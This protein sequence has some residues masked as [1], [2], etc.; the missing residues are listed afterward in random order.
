MNE[1]PERTTL[2]TGRKPTIQIRETF[3][4]SGLGPRK[5]RERVFLSLKTPSWLMTA[6][7]RDGLAAKRRHLGGYDR[8]SAYFRER[9]SREKISSPVSF[10]RS[11]SVR[12]ETPIP[13]AEVQK[14]PSSGEGTSSCRKLFS[15][16]EMK[17]RPFRRHPQDLPC[18]VRRGNGLRPSPLT[19]TTRFFPVLST[20]PR[21]LNID[22][23]GACVLRRRPFPSKVFSPC[24]RPTQAG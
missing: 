11:S 20:A 2:R 17:L 10:V 15:E 19:A 23:G 6:R 22:D 1:I 3:D 5:S 7:R 21:S 18:R 24:M 8:G 14:T 12:S 13:G 9:V 4:G 16:R